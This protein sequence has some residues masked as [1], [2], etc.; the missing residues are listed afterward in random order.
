MKKTIIITMIVILLLNLIYVPSFAATDAKGNLDMSQSLSTEP[1][2]KGLV[3]ITNDEGN[4]TKTGILGSSYSGPQTFKV[5]AIVATAIPRAANALFSAFVS[6]TSNNSNA[7]NKTFTIYD[8]VLGNYEIFNIDF[9][10]PLPEK[11]SDI[12]TFMERVKM[13]V[14][15]FYVFTRN[16]SIAISLFVLIYMGIR[17]AMST[18]ASQQ[19]KYKKM[20]IDWVASIMIL[21]FMHF[22][23]IVISYVLQIRTKYFRNFINVMET[24]RF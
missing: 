2:E 20:L 11:E 17:M 22:I 3:E 10:K 4:K 18:V 15:K 24:G 8:L 12:D 13:D 9:T 6:Q 16:L 23:I 1:Q 19:A 5:L 7:V 21:F 14:S